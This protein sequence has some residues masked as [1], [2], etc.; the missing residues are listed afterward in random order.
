MAPL[1]TGRG[2]QPPFTA[3]AHNRDNGLI[4]E[5]NAGHGPDEEESLKMDF[6]HADAADA[7]RLNAILWRDRKGKAPMPAPRHTMLP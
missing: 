1:F 2:E 7:D 3:D 4:Y 5:M 6:S